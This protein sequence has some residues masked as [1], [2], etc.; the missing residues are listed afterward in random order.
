MTRE[1]GG[2]MVMIVVVGIIGGIIEYGGKMLSKRREEREK[3]L[4]YECGFDT[5]GSIREE[6]DVKFYMIG[7]LFI[8]LDLEASYIFPWLVN[9][10]RIGGEGIIGMI[11]FIVE[12]MI[13]IVYVWRVG[14]LES[15]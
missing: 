3:M 12:L 15:K 2:I 13:G 6:Y 14:G 5:I 8:I 7:M 4:G 11:D 10:E 1:Y 9:L